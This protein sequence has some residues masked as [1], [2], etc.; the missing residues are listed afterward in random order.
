V[1]LLHGAAI[2]TSAN[3]KLKFK[4]QHHHPMMMTMLDNLDEYSMRAAWLVRMQASDHASLRAAC[5]RFQT[6]L[7]SETFHRD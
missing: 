7:D 1:L 3:K 6:I 4:Q 2:N 5:D